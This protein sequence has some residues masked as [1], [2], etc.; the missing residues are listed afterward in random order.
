MNYLQALTDLG[1]SWFAYKDNITMHV[2]FDFNEKLTG[3]ENRP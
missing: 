3:I 1:I 2:Q